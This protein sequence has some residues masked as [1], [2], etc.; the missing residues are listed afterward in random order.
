[1]S[2]LDGNVR[3]FRYF[4][5]YR[6]GTYISTQSCVTTLLYTLKGHKGALAVTSSN[7]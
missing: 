2:T 6:K 1:M 5:L 4:Y 7:L 3:A